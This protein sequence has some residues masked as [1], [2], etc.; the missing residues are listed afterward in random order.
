MDF[1]RYVLSSSSRQVKSDPSA[2][3]K[4]GRVTGLANSTCP[5][6]YQLQQLPPALMQSNH[7]T[8]IP[9]DSAWTHEEVVI[10]LR[11]LFPQIFEYFDLLPDTSSKAHFLVCSKDQRNLCVVADPVPNGERLLMNRGTKKAK[12]SENYICLGTSHSSLLYAQSCSCPFEQ[13]PASPSLRRSSISGLKTIL[14]RQ[15]QSQE[16]SS[17]TSIAGRKGKERAS[18]CSTLLLT[19]R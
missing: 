15:T 12:W 14:S 13:Q 4:A 19:C 2:Q 7:V 18:L 11:K 1:S 6:P 5:S 3:D 9:L 10:A 16:D 17:S 8:G